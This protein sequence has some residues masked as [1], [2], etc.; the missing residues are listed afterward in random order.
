MT[1][2]SQILQLI[3]DIQKEFNMAVILITHDLG[4]VAQVANRVCVMYAGKIVEQASIDDI[5]YDSTHPYTIG[6]LGSIPRVDKF[7]GERLKVIGGQPPSLINLP[8]GCAFQP[9]CEFAKYV[10]LNKCKTDTPSLADVSNNH[11]VSCHLDKS[12]VLQLKKQAI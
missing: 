2:Q 12:Q 5:F 11:K 3:R 8:S 1:V 10:T 7:H 9:R 6:L 4:V